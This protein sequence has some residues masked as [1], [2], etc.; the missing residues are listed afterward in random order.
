MGLL[1][2][3][4]LRRPGPRVPTLWVAV[5]AIML[6]MAVCP[7]PGAADGLRTFR[8]QWERYQSYFLR[9]D[10]R[11]IDTGNND[12]SHTE[13]QGTAMLFA[14]FAYDRPSFDR[15]WR[16]TFTHLAREDGL[17]SWKWDPSDGRGPIPDPNNATDGDL[18]IAWSLLLAADLWQHAPYASAA[19]RI[20]L[21]MEETVIE[22]FAGRVLLLPAVEGFRNRGV[23][24][25]NPSYCVF[26]AL[27]LIAEHT[28]RQIWRDA[29]EGCLALVQSADFGEVRLPVDWI[30][31]TPRGI[32][33]PAPDWPTRFGY[34]AI[35]VPIYLAWAGHVGPSFLGRFAD[36]WRSVPANQPPPSWIDPITGEKAQYEAST[37]F[38][39]TRQLVTY[40]LLAEAGRTS[41]AARVVFPGVSRKDDYY[42]ASLVMFASL[43]ALTLSS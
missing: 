5:L 18:L 10:G 42:S 16:W 37:G 9:D 31:M 24:V 40:A 22:R 25:L 27:D 4:G 34:D 3:A 11:I 33:T 8:A 39:A 36:A 21:A 28:Q 7:T 30:A 38:Y 13:G 29:Y 19:E 35:R 43:A 20:I 2:A 14:V 32:L 23:R 1:P 26:P 12:V 17:F 41:A 15:I 6:G